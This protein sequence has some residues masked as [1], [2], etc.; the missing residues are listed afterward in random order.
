MSITSYGISYRWPANLHERERFSN[1]TRSKVFQNHKIGY[2]QINNVNTLHY[3]LKDIR[4]F[5]EDE[6]CHLKQG[7]FNNKMNSKS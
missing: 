5:T 3:T 6:I 4:I 2:H 7:Y 1:Q